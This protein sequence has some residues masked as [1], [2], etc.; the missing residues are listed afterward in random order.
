MI[1]RRS[2][3]FGVALAALCALA[4]CGLG[5]G[6]APRGTQLTVTREFGRQLLLGSRA[7]RVAGAETVMSLLRRN[8]KVS[9]RYGGGFVEQIDGLAGNASGGEPH[10]WFYYVNGVQAPKGAAETEVHQGD[11][12]WWDLHDWSQAA[13]VPA[14]VGSFP[15]PFL[16]G[17]EG[18]RLPVRVECVEPQSAPCNTVLDRLRAL[19]VPAAL[20]AISGGEARYTLRVLVGPYAQLQIDPGARSIGRGPGQSGVYASF[21][22]D[23]SK[24]T[25]LDPAGRGTLVLGPHAGLVAAT[26]YHSEA[27]VWVV[28]GTDAVGV[29]LAAAAFDERSLR[30]RFALALRAPGVEVA[31]PDDR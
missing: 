11:H 15:E 26:R 12:V 20:A 16:A 6:K 27:P 14:V 10:D 24:L 19:G 7:P 28:T 21:S 23:G 18:K 4:G 9:T 29:K 17:I 1:S 5:A 30:N 3:A 25:L 22:P 13:E 8:V 2:P 31:L